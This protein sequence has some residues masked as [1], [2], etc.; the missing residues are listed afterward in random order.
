[1][2]VFLAVAC[3]V[4]L[5]GPW[6]VAEE[7]ELPLD[8]PG[9]K[10]GPGAELAGTQCRICHSVDYIITQPPLDRAGWAASVQKMREKYGAKLDTNQVEELVN[11]LSRTYGKKLP[12]P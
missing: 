4:L 1:M 11:Y 5:L 6:I 3:V 7:W 8:E 2:R 9:L 10:P 12:A